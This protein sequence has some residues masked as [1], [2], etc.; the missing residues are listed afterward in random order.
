LYIGRLGSTNLKFVAMIAALA[1]LSGPGW[2]Q[3]R[4]GEVA[5]ARVDRVGSTGFVQLEADSFQHLTPRQ[6]TLAYWLSQASIAINPIIY[7]QLS[8]FGL[9]QKRV[10]ELIVAHPEGIDRSVYA[11]IV[12]FTKLFWANRGNHNETTAQKF[13]PEFSFEDLR[14]AGLAALHHGG[15]GFTDA[16]YEKEIEDLRPS[17]FGVDFQPLITAKSPRAGQDILEASANNF[18]SGVKLSDLK[19]FTER[20]PLN[21]RLVK[22][23]GHLEEQVYRAGTPDHSVPPGLYAEYLAKANSYLE[24]AAEFAEPAQATAIRD[25][26]RFYQT[27]DF[28]DWLQFDVDWVA[29]NPPVDFANSFIEVYR[30]ARGAKAT[31]QSF[32]TVNDNGIESLMRKIASNAQYFEDHAPWA[33]Q[34]RKAGVKP[35]LAKAVETVVETGDFHVTTVGDN[36]PNEDAIHEKYGSKSFI[37]TNSSRALAH[38]AGYGMLEEF[39]ATPE[40]IALGKKYGDEAEDL[41]T[42]LH[43]VIGHGSGKLDPKLTHDPAFYLKEYYSTL[44]EARAD[45]MA[46]WSAWDPK[47]AQLGLVSSPDVAK[48]M[49][50]NAVE[51]AIM[52][53]RRIPKGDTIEEDHE[54]DRQLIVNYIRDKTDAIAEVKRGGKTYYEIRDFAKMRQGV[55]QLLAELMRI[56]AEGDYDAIKA[57][58]DKYGVHFDPALRDQVMERYRKLDIPTYWAGINPE[59]TASFD[60]A[61]KIVKVQISYPRDFV[62]QQLGYSAMYK[63]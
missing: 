24:K 48:V 21:S 37:F 46:L 10:L 19:D 12:A 63:Q 36:L 5:Q 31:S 44:E 7:D 51:V 41:M 57:L 43:E 6:Q 28:K 26:I 18:Y 1:L 34:Y 20:Y 22:V 15:S 3:S 61:G 30:D 33:P 56:K 25:L 52:Q 17:L 55:G 16:A 60:G 49:Y 40:E 62:K 13:L 27:G 39:A 4:S 32:V 50:Y 8:R 45:L 53:L 29:N 42:A 11:K 35:P 9:R 38:A 47:A 23:N 14:A 54:R 2:S 58:I 59:L